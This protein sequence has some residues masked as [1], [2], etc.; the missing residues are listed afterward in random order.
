MKKAVENG[1]SKA[2]YGNIDAFLE[3]L[4]FEKEIRAIIVIDKIT[5]DLENVVNQLTMKI[6]LLE[7]QTFISGDERIAKFIPFQEEIREITEGKDKETKV[8]E[9]DTIVVPA[10]EEGFKEVFL[11]SNQVLASKSDN[12]SLL[13][14]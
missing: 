6:D 12:L 1:F 2:G 10:N 8:Q 3:D 9:L 13:R 5:S 14:I 11:N 4:I 7:F